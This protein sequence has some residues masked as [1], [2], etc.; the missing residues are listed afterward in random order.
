MQL[1]IFGRLYLHIFATIVHISGMILHISETI[2]HISGMIIHNAST[3]VHNFEI[4]TSNILHPRTSGT[5]IKFV[6]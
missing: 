2:L 5:I 1:H 6:P 4:Y 3:I